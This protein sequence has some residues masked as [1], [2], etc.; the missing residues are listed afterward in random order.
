M[1]KL[2]GSGYLRLN[3]GHQLPAVG[4]G[5]WPLQ[6][7][8]VESVVMAAFEA[9]Y[10]LVDTASRYGNEDGV[11]RGVHASALPLEQVYVTTKLRGA[12]HGYDEALRA[13]DASS[14]RLGL[15]R[16]ALYLVH[17]PLPAKDRYVETWRALVRLREEGRIRSIG[18]SNFEPH[19]I[20][21]LLDATGVAPAVNQVELHPEFSQPALRRYHEERGILTQ[22]WRPL[23]K[24][25]SLKSPAVATIA[26]KHGKS[27]A[28]IILRWHFELGVLAIPKS[29]RADRLREN[30]SIF[31][32]Q[33]DAEDRKLL[34][35]LESGRRLGGH[36]D[37]HSEE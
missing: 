25:Q 10:R 26:G 4:F 6:N 9:G 24:G 15:E 32:F 1:E 12:D 30:I 29:E 17:W 33:L 5:T 37:T 28:Q 18:V 19:H 8:Q 2:A 11:G 13:F 31:D 22:A 3:D 34:A 36:P 27:A 23:G 20:D 35:T 16:I 21:R 7:G 14:K